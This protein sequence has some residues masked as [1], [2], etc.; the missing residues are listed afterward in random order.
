MITFAWDDGSDQCQK[1]TEHVAP[2]QGSYYNES[3]GFRG[4]TWGTPVASVKGLTLVSSTSD[5]VD[6]YS[7]KGD[8]LTFEGASVDSVLYGFWNGKFYSS[9][10]TF[11]SAGKWKVIKKALFEK[12][13]EGSRLRGEHFGW[14]GLKTDILARW[15]KSNNDGS[16]AYISTEVENEKYPGH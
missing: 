16:V 7:R 5:K 8:T 9:L 2:P 3:D 14:R 12:F 13:G 11:K 4:I 1:T 6:Y 15:D 10:V